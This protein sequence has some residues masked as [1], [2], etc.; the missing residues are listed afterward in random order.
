M[1]TN[2]Y[3]SDLN[4]PTRS[5]VGKRINAR[6]LVMTKHHN[7]EVVCTMAD[8]FTKHFSFSN[9]QLYSETS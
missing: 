4:E 7:K 5:C 6:R 9:V 3:I 8:V 2:Y 1:F